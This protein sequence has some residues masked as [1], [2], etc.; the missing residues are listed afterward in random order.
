MRIG[1]RPIS[2]D[3]PPY[4]IAEI[5]VNH[6]GDAGRALELVDAAAEAKADAVKIQFFEARR[7]M[8]RASALASYQSAAGESDP[9]AMLARLELPVG[10]MARVVERAHARGL[11]AI[12]TPFSTELVDASEPLGFD[13]YKTAS[14]DIIHRPLLDALVKTGRPLIISTG[15]ATMGEVS[16]AISWLTP[17]HARLAVL[18]CV[19]SY[20]TGLA[21][22]SLAGIADLR[23]LFPGPVGYS[24]HT[25]LVE[26]GA[27][28]VAAGAVILEKH[29]TYDN[30]AR[31]P[32]HL[33]SLNPVNFALYVRLARQ[34]WHMMGR[35]K[36]VL[37][38][39]QDVRRVSRQSVV[40]TRALEPGDT[41]GAAD[42]TIKRPG[43]GL[44]PSRLAGLIGRRV[45][46]RV[47]ADTPLTD[48]DFSRSDRTP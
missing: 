10:A 29:L 39:E 43:T 12:V 25:S 14:P 42:L 45:A 4:V 41:I 27:I 37:D 46:R 23:A 5:G 1:Q 44:E 40:T 28:A 13:A 22:A 47:E 9:I 48:D 26:S 30:H 11:H 17:A 18:Q 32:D 38:V 34:G 33:A 35:G 3:Y 2:K 19:S 15:A 7:L 6:D 24:D 36:E 21:S 16:R 31:G 8:S 20:P